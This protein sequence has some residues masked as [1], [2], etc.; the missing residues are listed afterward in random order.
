MVEI[1]QSK[2]VCI[3]ILR[4]DSGPGLELM[5]N[6]RTSDQVLK[7]LEGYLCRYL[8]SKFG[9]GE[10][11]TLLRTSVGWNAKGRE[12]IENIGK[13]PDYNM[14]SGWQTREVEL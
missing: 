2:D 11:E 3:D 9:V 1:Q 7:V 6:L 13:T 8:R 14:A 5:S 4:T 10:V 12:G